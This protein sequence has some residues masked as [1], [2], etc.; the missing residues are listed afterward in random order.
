M[1]LFNMTIKTHP[2]NTYISPKPFLQINFDAGLLVH[3]VINTSVF[4]NM[5]M[6]QKLFYCQ[7]NKSSVGMYYDSLHFL[8]SPFQGKAWAGI[9]TS[10]ASVAVVVGWRPFD[11]NKVSVSV[12][13]HFIS[14]H[15][16]FYANFRP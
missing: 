15:Y 4:L 3:D 8:I 6:R 1:E 14:R 9:L 10:Y 11:D 2:Q 12:K 16:E 7:H 13:F 5:M